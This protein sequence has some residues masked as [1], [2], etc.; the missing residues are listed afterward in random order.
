MMA[1]MEMC[2]NNTYNNDPISV[3]LLDKLPIQKGLKKGDVLPPV[4][5][6]FALEYAG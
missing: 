2:L 4:L 1:V 5:F 3:Y 6:I